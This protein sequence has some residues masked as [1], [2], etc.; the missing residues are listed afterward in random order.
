MRGAVTDKGSGA[1]GGQAVLTTREDGLL[2]KKGAEGKLF[3]EGATTQLQLQD[4]ASA[5]SSARYLKPCEPG[6]AAKAS[7][8][9]KWS[10]NTAYC[11]RLWARLPWS[12]HERIPVIPGRL[13]AFRNGRCTE[14]FVKIIPGFLAPPHCV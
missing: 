9:T 14:K 8:L 1:T 6:R 7:S 12:H 10:W 4:S 5:E 2:Q 3:S 13:H 11:Q